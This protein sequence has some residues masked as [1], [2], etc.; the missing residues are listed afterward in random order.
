MSNEFPTVCHVL[1]DGLFNDVVKDY[2]IQYPSTYYNLNR[3]GSKFPNYLRG[4]VQE[5]PYQKIVASVAGV[6]RAM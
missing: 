2:V 3:R 6:E 4:E 5:I 1:G